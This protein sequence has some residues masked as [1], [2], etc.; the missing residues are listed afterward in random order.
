MW[1]E[2]EYGAAQELNSPLGGTG[3]E[4]AGGPRLLP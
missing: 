3:R 1:E 2:A 4:Q